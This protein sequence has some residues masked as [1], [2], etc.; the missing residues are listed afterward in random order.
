MKLTLFF[1]RHL[2]EFVIDTIW[3][4]SLHVIFLLAFF[5]YF[6]NCFF[7]LFIHFLLSSQSLPFWLAVVLV[8]LHVNFLFDIENLKILSPSIIS[9]SNNFSSDVPN[10]KEVLNFN[11]IRLISVFLYGS[12]FSSFLFENSFPILR[13]QIYFCIFYLINIVVLLFLFRSLVHLVCLCM[14]S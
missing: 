1:F 2:L 10:W 8:F 5:F 6:M 3:A 12:C 14:W 13:S 9:L 4:W 7:I 11:I